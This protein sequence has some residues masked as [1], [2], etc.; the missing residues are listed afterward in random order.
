MHLG[1]C[2]EQS[3]PLKVH[4]EI[5]QLDHRFR[6]GMWPGSVAERNS[7]PG[8]QLVHAEGLGEVIV[9]SKIECRDFGTLGLARREYDNRRARSPSN[10]ANHLQAV[11]VWQSQIEQNQ[12]RSKTRVR[13]KTF[14]CRGGGVDSK[15]M[16]AEVRLHGTDNAD[17][18]V[19]DQDPRPRTLTHAPD[20]ASVTGASAG[21][22]PK[23]S[24][25]VNR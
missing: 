5:A 15:I 6:P 18:V 25:K 24:V 8:E 12:V 21:A 10:L 11:H 7:H 13:F 23:G 17:L 14:C 1:A 4:L 2:D 22:P 16:S 19:D 3:S 9:R 20:I